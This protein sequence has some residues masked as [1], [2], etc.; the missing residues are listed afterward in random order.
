MSLR[1]GMCMAWLVDII[2]RNVIYAEWPKEIY[3]SEECALFWRQS[4]CQRGRFFNIAGSTYDD[5]QEAKKDSLISHSRLSFSAHHIY[6]HKVNFDHSIL[7]SLWN[8]LILREGALHSRTGLHN[9][10]GQ[11]KKSC[12]LY[13]NP[14]STKSV[15]CL[16]VFLFNI[17]YQNSNDSSDS[18]EVEMLNAIIFNVSI[19]TCLSL[20][21]N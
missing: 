8:T 15:N 10:K 1:N 21:L 9:S 7:Q 5:N 20:K 18:A 6:A 12:F 13:W 17:L 4:L 3:E 14:R 11:L 19:V 2:M 16:L